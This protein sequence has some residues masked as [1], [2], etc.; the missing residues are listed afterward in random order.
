MHPGTQKAKGKN[1][2]CFDNDGKKSEVSPK[3]TLFS[4]PLL[5]VCVVTLQ[6]YKTIYQKVKTNN[7]GGSCRQ[8][9]RSIF[10]LSLAKA[11]SEY[12]YESNTQE[13][14]KFSYCL[15]V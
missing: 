9:L 6:H 2:L 13:R 10:H 11:G 8:T 15:S 5:R 1:T 7:Q 4:W 14:Y 12:V 3:D